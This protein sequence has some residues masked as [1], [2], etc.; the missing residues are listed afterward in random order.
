MESGLASSRV[1]RHGAQATQEAPRDKSPVPNIS[2]TRAE[3]ATLPALSN[4]RLLV[5]LVLVLVVVVVRRL[6]RHA[7]RVLLRLHRR[8]ALG[9]RALLLRVDRLVRVLLLGRLVLGVLAD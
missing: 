5:V 1:T 7:H 2:S 3:R 8:L 6:E 9:M 4:N